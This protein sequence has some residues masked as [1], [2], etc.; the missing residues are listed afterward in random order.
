ML[1]AGGGDA[2]GHTILGKAVAAEH[3]FDGF[4]VKAAKNKNGGVIKIRNSNIEIRNNI[5]IRIF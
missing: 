1:R 5:E 3:G 2:W 4:V